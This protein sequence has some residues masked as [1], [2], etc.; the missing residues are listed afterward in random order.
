MK[1]AVMC[2]ANNE[3]HYI[4]EWVRYHI[5]LGFSEVFVFQNNWRF[6]EAPYDDP[7]IH[8]IEFDG[9]LR[10]NPCYNGFISEHKD[11]FDFAMFLDADEFLV[12]NG[13]TSLDSALER[14]VDTDC[15]YV[16]WRIFGDSGK[17][18][19]ENHDYSCVRR[20]TMA[21][22]R[23]HR[24]GKNILNFKKSGS[25]FS[26]YNPHIVLMDGKPFMYSDSNGKK[27]EII[28]EVWPKEDQALELFHYRN[29]TFCEFY[30]R[31]F[32]KYDPLFGSSQIINNDLNYIKKSF[33]EFNTNKVENL[34]AY[35]VMFG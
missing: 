27:M 4:D 17:S 6:P 28:W 20:F 9:P 29:K 16:N 22:D 3:D 7:R 31:K 21:D 15:V 14:Y 23:L 32:L 34:T 33:D 24:L 2:I 18:K 13:G 1:S 5:K 35:K 26:F 10:M 12:V 8:F 30:N 11:D 19:V 25:R